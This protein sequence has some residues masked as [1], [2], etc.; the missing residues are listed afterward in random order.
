MNAAK[1]PVFHMHV[2]FESGS[3]VSF[4]IPFYSTYYFLIDNYELVPS[5]YLSPNFF[6][7]RA[8]QIFQSMLVATFLVVYFIII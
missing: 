8:A 6:W 4:C 3:I 5:P 1:Q 7:I 2:D